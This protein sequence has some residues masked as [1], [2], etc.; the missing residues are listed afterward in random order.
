M[1]RILI[2]DDND[3][4]RKMI[5]SVLALEGFEMLEAEDGKTGIE[6]AR[7]RLPHLIICD[8]SMPEMDGYETLQELR[9]DSHTATIPFIFLTGLADNPRMRQAMELGADDFIS[10]PVEVDGLIK[11]V[12]T[13]LKKQEL[14]LRLAEKKL[15]DLRANISLSLPHELRT[16]LNAILGFS[17][18]ISTDSQTLETSEIAEMARQIHKAGRRLHRSL[19]NFLV[20]AQ[21]EL[22]ASDPQKLELIRSESTP[23]CEQLIQIVVRQKA[24]EYKRPQDVQV[25]TAS[26]VPAIS[27]QYLTKIVEELI[28]NALKFSKEGKMVSVRAENK[29]KQLCL[30]VRDSGNG[31]TPEQIAAVGAYMQFDR[32]IKEQQGSGLGLAITKRLTELHSGTLSLQ[33]EKGV[34]TTVTVHLPLSPEGS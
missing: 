20:Y 7:R 10:K 28:D 14:M 2:I 34:G 25:V 33:S 30:T 1:Q 24:E 29:D 18:I 17:E 13:R 16:P 3:D 27:S 31:M 12:T 22:L 4:L 15:E 26:S 8:I 21:I 11:A 32:R 23:D 6:L 19:E 9:K 5:G